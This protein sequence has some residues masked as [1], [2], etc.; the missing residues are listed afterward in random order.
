MSDQ[1]LVISEEKSRLEA[2][3]TD[4]KTV[5]VAEAIRYRKRAQQAE[6]Q[7]AEAQEELSQQRQHVE[8]LSEQLSAIKRQAALREA[9]AEAGAVDME[10]AML[11]AQ[12]RMTEDNDAEPTTVIEQL[13]SDKAYLFATP[14]RLAATSK[15]AG[16]R[17]TVNPGST[18][19]T[20]AQRAAESNSRADMQA[21]L[22][23][24]RAFV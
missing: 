7:L 4:E 17:H 18:L 9:L 8:G 3:G 21:Y 23:A 1:E 13:R 24:R 11:L 12:A 6:K 14:Q 5:P 16:L 20:A 19:Q 10:T 22:Q 2:G 15:T